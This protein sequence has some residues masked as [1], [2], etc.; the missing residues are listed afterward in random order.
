MYSM[1]AALLAAW[2]VVMVQRLKLSQ[3]TS[4]L[5]QP[6]PLTLVM[7]FLMRR[8]KIAIAR[9]EDEHSRQLKDASYIGRLVSWVDAQEVV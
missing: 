7:W 5:L 3:S 8:R 6:L 9:G 4:K 2:Q 1:R